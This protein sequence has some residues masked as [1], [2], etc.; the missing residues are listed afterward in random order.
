MGIGAYFISHTCD[1]KQTPTPAWDHSLGRTL[2]AVFWGNEVLHSIHCFLNHSSPLKW[3]YWNCQWGHKK[4]TSLL[5]PSRYRSVSCMPFVFLSPLDS[6][7]SSQGQGQAQRW[8]LGC[9]HAII[10]ADLCQGIGDSEE[11]SLKPGTNFTWQVTK[12][13]PAFVLKS[14]FTKFPILSWPSQVAACLQALVYKQG[15]A[16][17]CSGGTMKEVQKTESQN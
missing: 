9:L 15:K 14:G 13:A 11:G 6:T 10:W 8:S 12:L 4:E 2:P 3:F 17:A 16:V 7:S 1:S 5:Y